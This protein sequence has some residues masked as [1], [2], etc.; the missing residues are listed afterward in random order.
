MRSI[1]IELT[2]ALLKKAYSMVKGGCNEE[3]FDSFDI[4]F[5][6]VFVESN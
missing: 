1:R 5:E 2:S 3:F 6:L 4:S